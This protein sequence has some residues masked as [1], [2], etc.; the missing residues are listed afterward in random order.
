VEAALCAEIVPARIKSVEQ[1]ALQ[2]RHRTRFWWM[3]KRTSRINA[4]R[5]FCRELGIV[6][7]RG[8]RLGVEQIGRVLVDLRQG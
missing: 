7:A 3:A 5:G 6:I 2:A 4:P 8:R 1:Q